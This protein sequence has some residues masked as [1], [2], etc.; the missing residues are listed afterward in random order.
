MRREERKERE[1][2]REGKRESRK[3]KEERK[4]TKRIR[5]VRTEGKKKRDP[6]KRGRSRAPLITF[7]SHCHCDIYFL[8]LICQSVLQGQGQSMNQWQGTSKRTR[9]TCSSGVEIRRN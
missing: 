7:N 4:Q 9:R 6:S 2:E 3:G 8:Y 5:G 1:M